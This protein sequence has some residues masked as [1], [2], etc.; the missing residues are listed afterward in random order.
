MV[1][2]GNRGQT[3]VLFR[4][5]VPDK[6]RGLPP[7]SRFPQGTHQIYDEQ[8]KLLGVRRKI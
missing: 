6:N 3:T 4:F 2:G 1:T 7:V 5:A 8:Q